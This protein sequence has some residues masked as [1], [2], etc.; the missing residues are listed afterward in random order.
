L[1][2]AAQANT[3]RNSQRSLTHSKLNRMGAPTCAWVH[4]CTPSDV[5]RSPAVFAYRFFAVFAYRLSAVFAYRALAPAH[6]L[7]TVSLL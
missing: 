1:P 4:P 3:P 7:F 2:P 6:P 5:P